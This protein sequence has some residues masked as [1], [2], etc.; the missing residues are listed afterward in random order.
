MSTTLECVIDIA[1]N[2]VNQILRIGERK[3]KKGV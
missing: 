3:K 2:A 1:V